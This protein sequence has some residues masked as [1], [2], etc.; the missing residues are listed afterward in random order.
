MS[1]ANPGSFGRGVDILTYTDEEF[2]QYLQEPTW[3]RE[4]TDRLFRMCT[5]FGLR[6]VAIH[7]RFTCP[8]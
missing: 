3:T 6:F 2:E 8:G 4:Q 5:R 7:D 1:G